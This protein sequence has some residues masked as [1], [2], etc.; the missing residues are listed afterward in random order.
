MIKKK[1]ETI[2]CKFDD[3][4]SIYKGE[5]KNG[6]FHGHGIL[7]CSQGIY[8]EG[9][10]KDNKLDGKGIYTNI[11]SN[12]NFFHIDDKMTGKEKKT[13][14][15]LMK[16]NGYTSE[17]MPPAL[18]FS[19]KYTSEFNI[20]IIGQ[21]KN[22]KIY[23]MTDILTPDGE[24]KRV[25]YNKGKVD[26]REFKTMICF[27]DGTFRCYVDDEGDE[28]S[29]GTERLYSEKNNRILKWKKDSYIKSFENQFLKDGWFPNK[30]CNNKKQ[31]EVLLSKWKEQNEKGTF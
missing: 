30:M 26:D 23:G 22:N 15:K 24:H 3:T 21:F 11:T 29:Q 6:K 14:T 9:N 8:Y 31:F 5:V 28:D 16:D 17:Y 2:K 20:R 1:I 7:K 25:L 18:D 4:H 13:F 27:Y 10:F 12:F 19:G